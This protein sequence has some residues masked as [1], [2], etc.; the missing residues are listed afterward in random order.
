MLIGNQRPRIEYVPGYSRSRGED[1]IELSRNAGLDLD[2]WQKYVIVNSLGTRNDGKWSAF[3]VKLLV[4]RQ[5]GKGS[6]LECR[7]LAGLFLFRTDRLLL[8]TAH[9]QR[10]STEHYHRI[11]SLIQNTPELDRR[12]MRNNSAY[13]LESIW[14][15]PGPTVILGSGGRQVLRNESSRLLFIARS[16]SSGRGFTGDF[17]AYDEDMKLKAAQVGASLPALG[18]RPNPQVFYAGSAGDENSEQVGLIRRRG[19]EAAE[20]GHSPGRLFFAEWSINWHTEYCN[21]DCTEHDDP[22]DERSVA[23]ANPSYN[24][25]R[26]PFTIAAERDALS[27]AQFERE[28]LGVG[29]YPVPGDAWMVI[30]KKWFTATT[31][32]TGEPPR[33]RFPVFAI[34]VAQDRGSASISVAGLRPDG[35]IGLQV[36]DHREHTGWIMSRAGEIQDKWSPAAWIVDKRA[37]TNTVLVE[38]ERAGLPVKT[39][40]ATDVAA[41]SGQLYDAMRDDMVRHYGQLALRTA[42]AAVTTRNL[43]ESWAFDRINS[44]ADQTPLMSAAFAYWGYMKYGAE[45]DYDAAGSV[46]FDLAEIRRLYRLGIYGPDDLRRLYEEDLISD[47]D[48]EKLAGEG[49]FS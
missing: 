31:D 34:E 7:E 23:R 9:E 24:V 46:H 32:D 35:R 1:A 20:S 41:A 15:K 47:K 30:P 21:P 49:L 36:T 2:D 14:L 8:H 37:A 22:E 17:I 33:V 44:A 38:L 19:I 13:G 26:M 10:T 40:T 6:I 25:R 28:I 39:M 18:A 5:A 29:K 48:I 12:V 42:L 43:S 11:W 4:P 45:E 27:S 3:E 16:G